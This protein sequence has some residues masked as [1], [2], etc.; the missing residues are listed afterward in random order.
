MQEDWK[1]R[2]RTG[3]LK[4]LTDG[5][6]RERRMLRICRRHAK[7][8]DTVRDVPICLATLPSLVLPSIRCKVWVQARVPKERTR[9]I[10]GVGMGRGFPDLTWSLI[11][12]AFSVYQYYRP[13]LSSDEKD[14]YSIIP[15]CHTQTLHKQE[16]RRHHVCALH[17]TFWGTCPSHPPPGIDISGV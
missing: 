5:V 16:L 6:R 3:F 8:L 1:A 2:A 10:D 13:A 9:P 4:R 12:H 14:N 7:Q 17:S 15:Q 11:V